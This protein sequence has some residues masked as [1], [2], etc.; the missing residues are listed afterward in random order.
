[1]DDAWKFANGLNPAVN[2]RA[3][4]LDGD[5]LSN[6][7][8]YQLGSRADL[9]DTNGNGLPDGWQLQHFGRLGIDP[10]ADPD[11]DGLTNL[12]EYQRGTNPNNADSDGD[13]ILDGWEITNGLNPL[14]ND[15]AADPDGDGFTN[16]Q[17]F[18]LGR[19]P[20]KPAILDTTEAVNLRLY[21]PNR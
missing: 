18:L 12:Q 20:M 5:G 16:F 3:G 11:R 15:A 17:E 6:I 7:R 19:N 13:G 21:V 10:N 4:D 1:M 9:A 14:V 2:D 8:E